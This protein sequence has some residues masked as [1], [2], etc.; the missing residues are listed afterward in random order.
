MGRSRRGTPATRALP[1]E[2]E[3]PWSLTLRCENRAVQGRGGDAC[4]ARE[5]P[6]DAAKAKGESSR[7]RSYAEPSRA[8]S[9]IGSRRY[10]VRRTAEGGWRGY[11]REAVECDRALRQL[12]P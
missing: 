4:S 12:K 9:M 11:P 1:A 3:R 2:G 8:G 10:S 7:M 6:D 5:P